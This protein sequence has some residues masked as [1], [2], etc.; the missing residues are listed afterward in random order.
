MRIDVEKET[1]FRTLIPASLSLVGGRRGNVTLPHIL[2]FCTGDDE[3]PVLG[4]SISPSI[5]FVESLTGFLPTA[6]TCINRMK[7][8]RATHSCPL[9]PVEDLHNL[10]DY[11]FSSAYLGII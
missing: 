1:Y 2:R 9:P 4:Y 6:N 10:Y 11:A 5:V 3:E 7:L 8:P